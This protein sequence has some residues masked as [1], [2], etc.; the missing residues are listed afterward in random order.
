[1]VIEG[2]GGV[3]VPINQEEMLIDL[4][5]KFSCGVVL[6]S[7][8]YVGSINHTLLSIAALRARQLPILGLVFN[9]PPAPECEEYIMQHSGVPALLTIA[10]EAHLNPEVIAHYALRLQRKLDELNLG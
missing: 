10:R 7:Q 5:K 8:N 2:A 1:M 4:A 9:G 6:A 3:L